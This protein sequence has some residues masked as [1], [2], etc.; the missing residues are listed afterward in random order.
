MQQED[1]DQIRQLEAEDIDGAGRER[2]IALVKGGQRLRGA[3]GLVLD[4]PL[5]QRG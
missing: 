4:V 3:G 5:N 1:D 2:Q